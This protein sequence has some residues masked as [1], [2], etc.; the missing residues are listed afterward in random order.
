MGTNDTCRIE[1]FF[2]VR[3]IA[4]AFQVHPNTVRRW[5]EVGTLRAVR[6]GHLLR[7]SDSELKRFA[8]AFVRA[9]GTEATETQDA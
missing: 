1:S 5:I 8:S 2:G 3:Q 9:T 7:V 6:V 4:Q